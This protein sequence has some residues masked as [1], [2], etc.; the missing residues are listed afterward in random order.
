MF[1]SECDGRVCEKQSLSFVQNI[2]DFRD[3]HHKHVVG[4]LPDPFATVFLSKDQTLNL[5]GGGFNRQTH[6]TR[7]GSTKGGTKCEIRL[8][9]G[10]VHQ[11]RVVV[12]ERGGDE[13]ARAG[14]ES[15]SI[16]HV[17]TV[18][19][20]NDIRAAHR[21][22]ESPTPESAFVALNVDVK[23]RQRLQAISTLLRGKRAA[24]RLPPP[25][26]VNVQRRIR[27]SAGSA[28][29]NGHASIEAIVYDPVLTQAKQQRGFARVDRVSLCVAWVLNL[30]VPR[31]LDEGGCIL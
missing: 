11:R 30:G 9:D 24:R 28:A 23:I 29:D 17:V 27:R 1:T 5:S 14:V 13:L 2:R 15:E 31:N 6:V 12:A 20:V 26:G 25:F 7:E 10:N 4:V 22:C 3:V 16:L 8:P 19:P 21:A 18:G